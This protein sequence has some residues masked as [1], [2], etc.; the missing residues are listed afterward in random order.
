LA[1]SHTYIYALGP[2][3]KKLLQAS[4]IKRLMRTRL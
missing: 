4:H 3:N 2:Q 1:L